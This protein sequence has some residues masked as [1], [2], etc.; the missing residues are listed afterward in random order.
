MEKEL[1]AKE[2]MKEAVAP[3]SPKEVESRLASKL[4]E[5]RLELHGKP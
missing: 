5:K 3:Y 1:P 4:G 2:S